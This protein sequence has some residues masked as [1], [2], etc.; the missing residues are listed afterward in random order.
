MFEII[1]S[2]D[3]RE[4]INRKGIELT[5]WNKAALIYNHRTATYDE[6]VWALLDLQNKTEDTLLKEQIRERLDRDKLFY[7]KFKECSENACYILK[8]IEGNK[9]ID[10]EYHTSFEEAHN[11]GL[12]LGSEFAITKDSGKATGV[13]GTVEYDK[14]GHKQRIIVLYCV[15]EGDYFDENSNYRFENKYIDAPLMFRRKDIVHIIGTELYGIVDRPIDGEDERSTRE[16]L[17]KNSSVDYSDFQIPVNLIY[18]GAKFLSVFS[19]EHIAPTDLEFAEL[20]EEDPRKGM[21]EY[22]MKTLY[23]SSW[24]GG[25]GRDQG[26]INAILTELEIVWRQYPDLRLGQLLINVCGSKPLFAIEDEML[27][28]RLQYNKFPVEE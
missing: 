7:E 1:A 4:F 5:D 16:S 2:R 25:S 23:E 13:F 14:Q 11:G 21:L 18:D 26:R 17:S 19:H 9:Y 28:D 20:P 24:F 27:L 12:S 22:M 3:Y 8:T 6:K 15:G 10:E